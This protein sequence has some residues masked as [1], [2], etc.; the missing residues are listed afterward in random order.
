MFVIAGFTVVLLY[1]G[2]LKSVIPSDDAKGPVGAA[3]FFLY[4]LVPLL[5]FNY[6]GAL[7]HF[8]LHHSEK[9]ISN[10]FTIWFWICMAI[11]LCLIALWAG[12]KLSPTVCS[13]IGSPADLFCHSGLLFCVNMIILIMILISQKNNLT[14]AFLYSCIFEGVFAI[15]VKVYSK[16]IKCCNDFL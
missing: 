5:I 14:Q 3:D 6:S 4:F 13:N 10:S 15:L 9:G 1:N 12:Y 11:W 8:E 16:G 2:I 7:L